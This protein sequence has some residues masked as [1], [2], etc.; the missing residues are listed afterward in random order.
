LFQGV[1]PLGVPGIEKMAAALLGRQPGPAG[2]GPAQ[3]QQRLMKRLPL[4]FAGLQQGHE[5]I[6]AVFPFPL[7]LKSFNQLKRI[8][9]MIKKSNR[10]V[11]F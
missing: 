10:R 2:D 1:K 4:E 8:K 7:L 5:P 9:K 6:Q 3:M 11:L